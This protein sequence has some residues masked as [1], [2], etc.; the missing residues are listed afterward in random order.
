MNSQLPSKLKLLKSSV[1]FI[2]VTRNRSSTTW[3]VDTKVKGTRSPGEEQRQSRAR[4]GVSLHGCSYRRRDAV[5]LA[6]HCRRPRS[7][8]C[9]LTHRRPPVCS[10]VILSLTRS[11]RCA[12]NRNV[13]L[14]ARN[15]VKLIVT[16]LVK[17][18]VAHDTVYFGKW[19]PTPRLTESAGSF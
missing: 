15:R 1:E 6:S 3:A 2:P 4:G 19:I 5:Q 16:Q 14:P 13:Q 7:G 10:R 9:T 18:F 12:S 8:C 17:I 11:P